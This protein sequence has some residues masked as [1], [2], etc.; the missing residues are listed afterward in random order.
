MSSNDDVVK[1]RFFKDAPRGSVIF[2]HLK[3]KNPPKSPNAP[4]VSAIL[5]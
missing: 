4:H 2:E 1:R 3:M 5:G